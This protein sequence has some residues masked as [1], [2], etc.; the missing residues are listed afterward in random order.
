MMDTVNR[1]LDHAKDEVEDKLF[2]LLWAATFLQAGLMLWETGWLVRVSELGTGWWGLAGESWAGKVRATE[3]TSTLYLIFQMAYMGK[4]EFLRWTKGIA[5][6]VSVKDGSALDDQEVARRIRRGDVA[7]V[8]WGVLALLCGLLYSAS[9]IS[10]I[11]AELVRTT[12]QVVGI[13][14]FAA[15][16]K[17]YQK[18]K[19]RH[20]AALAETGRAV[21][22]GTAARV[23]S[24]PAVPSAH[25][26]VDR[27]DASESSARILELLRG[28]A[29]MKSSDIARALSLGRSRTQE[30]LSALVQEGELTRQ[31]SA[32]S[33]T[34]SRK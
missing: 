33:V 24:A 30:L 29:P 1:A 18:N 34:Y 17:G 28:H 9:L 6:I 31:G 19:D 11:P 21:P 3:V 26:S 32:R 23:P 4:K 20:A 10:R 13:Y 22:S 25:P 14:A 5:G 8:F 12:V 16:S 15:A 7:I 2:G 27:Q